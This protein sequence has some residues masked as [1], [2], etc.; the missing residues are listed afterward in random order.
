MC[1]KVLP[2]CFAIVAQTPPVVLV[3]VAKTE[4][5][6]NAYVTTGA[7]QKLY[8]TTQLQF[9]AGATGACVLNRTN[10]RAEPGDENAFL[11]H[12]FRPGRK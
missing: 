9:L 6:R 3:C 12:R 4:L 7:F 10:V 11:D 2:Y 8:V 1:E 5:F